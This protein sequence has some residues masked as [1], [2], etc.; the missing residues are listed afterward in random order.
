MIDFDIL[1]PNTYGAPSGTAQAGASPFGFDILGTPQ[2][3]GLLQ[4]LSPAQGNP[5]GQGPNSP[6]FNATP[7]AGQPQ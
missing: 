3:Q 6:V 7:L 4:G 2:G 1:A 5:N